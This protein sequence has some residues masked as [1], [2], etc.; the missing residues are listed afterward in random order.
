MGHEFR[1]IFY[2]A[3]CSNLNPIRETVVVQQNLHDFARQYGDRVTIWFSVQGDPSGGVNHQGIV[4]LGIGVMPFPITQ[5]GVRT[6]HETEHF[7]WIAGEHQTFKIMGNHTTDIDIRELIVK[8]ELN[9]NLNFTF[10]HE[11]EKLLLATFRA[12][13]T[14]DYNGI[15]VSDDRIP[16]GMTLTFYRDPNPEIP[17]YINSIEPAMKLTARY[18]DDQ[19]VSEIQVPALD[20]ES[21]RS[22]KQASDYAWGFI[23]GESNTWRGVV[24]D[25]I[26]GFLLYGDARDIVKNLAYWGVA[27][28]EDADW[29]TTAVA[30]L[31]LLADIGTLFTG[32]VAMPINIAVGVLKP[33]LRMMRK[34]AESIPLLKPLLDRVGSTLAREVQIIFVKWKAGELAAAGS[35][36]LSIAPLFAALIDYFV[37]SAHQ[38]DPRV[39][40]HLVNFGKRCAGEPVAIIAGR[41]AY[42]YWKDIELDLNTPGIAG[43]IAA[44]RIIGELV[45]KR[46]TDLMVF[47]NPQVNSIDEFIELLHYLA[48]HP[49][50]PMTG[51]QEFGLI[52]K[53]REVYYQRALAL[54]NAG[55][56]LPHWT[57][58]DASK[59]MTKFPDRLHAV[60]SNISQ[61]I[62]QLA[63]SNAYLSEAALDGLAGHIFYLG[64]Y[65]TQELIMRFAPQHVSHT[66]SAATQ[67]SRSLLEKIG[68]QMN[69]AFSAATRQVDELRLDP[70]YSDLN[71][72]NAEN[73]F[74]KEQA[75]IFQ[76]LSFLS[77][78]HIVHGTTDK[79]GW[80]TL[81][82]LDTLERLM[83][84][85][86]AHSSSRIHIAPRHGQT[87][88]KA[89]DLLLLFEEPVGNI[90]S[91][92][93]ISECKALYPT[94]DGI[95]ESVDRL[96]KQFFRRLTEAMKRNIS[97][98]F[99][100]FFRGRQE[101]KLVD[102]LLEILDSVFDVGTWWA[103]VDDKVVRSADAAPNNRP[104]A[105]LIIEHGDIPF[106]EL[107]HT[108]KPFDPLP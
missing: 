4:R 52:A 73:F 37:P 84:Q 58:V 79:I 13:K 65:R 25:M 51:L 11:S 94:S 39:A 87:T 72:D 49:P 6:Y 97:L 28:G 56:S 68:I 16:D 60:A 69:M 88:E 78:G 61:I 104:A 82:E 107:E 77:G 46:F 67:Q 47:L 71:L 29:L 74:S 83:T 26:A 14:S 34:A 53:R 70:H 2:A 9:R 3:G 17:T 33:A 1:F 8:T 98:D 20:I 18:C 59:W 85:I 54:T 81:W 24:G 64:P 44:V 90:P 102:A 106:Q 30:T 38:L 32:G 7:N 42:I 66:V 21:W 5:G 45:L 63:V 93:W 108:S 12:E 23:T 103:R 41:F 27:G 19:S 50:N 100:Y 96:Q 40:D 92:H 80:G 35:L 57:H 101:E 43:E 99:A 62:R 76:F 75:I 105:R 86:P 22:Y 10:D 55:T 95:K 15:Q 89:E 31:G 91:G 48:R 36:L